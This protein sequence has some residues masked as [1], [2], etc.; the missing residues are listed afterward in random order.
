MTLT[1][2]KLTRARIKAILPGGKLTE[3]GITAERLASGDLRWAI[4]IMVDGQRIHRVVG[5]ESE[6][7]TREQAERLIETLRTRARE[8][9]LSLPK[10]RKTAITFGKAGSDYLLRLATEGG[11]SIPRKRQHLQDRL[12]P[13]FAAY[14]L[15]GITEGDT[16]GY[17]R[18]RQQS[19]AKPGT[20]N[21]ELATLSHL[22]RSATKW[23]WLGSGLV[24]HSQKIT[25]AA[26]ATA[27]KK[28]VGQRS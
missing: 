7:V 2:Q 5:R 1:Y 12:G 25:V 27:E 8:D 26:R 15:D 11:K 10:G 20:I 19:G 24:D 6:G 4:N 18:S 23:G 16:K 3:G 9:R 13:F 21:R 17:A 22:L 14:K 28:T